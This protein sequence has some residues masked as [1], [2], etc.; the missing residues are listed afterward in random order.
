MP[1]YSN[2]SGGHLYYSPKTRKWFV[3]P[4]FTPET[5]ETTASIATEGSVPVGDSTWR[6]YFS[7]QWGERVLTVTELSPTEADAVAAAVEK[8][9]V[10]DLVKVTPGK[11]EW[12]GESSVKC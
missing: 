6:Y 5:D 7:K 3:T 8:S 10:K 4:S 12:I 11:L 9:D 1:H 2:G